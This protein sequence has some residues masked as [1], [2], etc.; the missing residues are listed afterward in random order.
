MLTFAAHLL[1]MH[2]GNPRGD[3]F[4]AA[5][6]LQAVQPACGCERAVVPMHLR[7]PAGGRLPHDAWG[8]DTPLGCESRPRTGT[9]AAPGGVGTDRESITARRA[10]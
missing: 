8:R 1:T 6:G 5:G 10:T 2:T 4:A 3:R 7:E 9:G